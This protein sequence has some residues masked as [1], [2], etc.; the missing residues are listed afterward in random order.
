MGKRTTVGPDPAFLIAPPGLGFP[1]GLVPTAH[2][3]GS[4]SVAPSGAGESRFTASAL[5]KN[6]L[7]TDF[8]PGIPGGETPPSTAG[9]TPAATEARLMERWAILHNP[10]RVGAFPSSSLANPKQ[11]VPHPGGIQCIGNVG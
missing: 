7:L 8:E 10:V 9:E 6:D 2:A 3:V 5:F 11:R 4:C 1:S